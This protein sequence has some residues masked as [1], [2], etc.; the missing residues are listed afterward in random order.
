M[1]Y[2]VIKNGVV[3]NIIE[4]DGETPYQYPEEG[5]ELIQSDTAGI[6]DKYINGEFVKEEPKF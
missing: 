2:A 3:I 5:V 1:K 6:G 4:W